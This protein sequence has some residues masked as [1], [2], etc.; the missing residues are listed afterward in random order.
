MTRACKVKAHVRKLPDRL[1]TAEKHRKLC[2]R[3]RLCPAQVGEA[4]HSHP[5]S[6]SHDGGGRWV[7]SSIHVDFFEP[8]EITRDE[9]IKLQE[10]VTAIC[11]RYQSQEPWQDHRG[12]SATAR[13]SHQPIWSMTITPW[14][15]TDSELYLEMLRREDF[16][17]LRKVW[18]GRLGSRA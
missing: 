10:I 1:D 4:D 9:E 5:G 14:S 15:S 3:D 8:V 6:F 12:C 11:D 7:I 2:C 18:A 16:L 13:G 17:A